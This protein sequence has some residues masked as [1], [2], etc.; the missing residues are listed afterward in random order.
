MK[1]HFTEKDIRMANKYM[2]V[3]STALTFRE[4]P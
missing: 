2:K 3:C 4:K 1:T